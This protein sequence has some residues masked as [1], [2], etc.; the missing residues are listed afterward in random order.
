M[1]LYNSVMKKAKKIISIAIGFGLATYL[2]TSGFA[3]L[4]AQASTQV[5]ISK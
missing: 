5:N 1:S 3:I 2:L 4:D